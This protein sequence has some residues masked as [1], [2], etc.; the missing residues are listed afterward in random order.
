MRGPSVVDVDVMATELPPAAA[1]ESDGIEFEPFEACPAA[2]LL[3]WR[4]PELICGQE[5]IS[6]GMRYNLPT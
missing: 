6:G 1:A 2:F 4:P 5:S 3:L